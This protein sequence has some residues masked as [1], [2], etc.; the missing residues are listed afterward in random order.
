M[1]YHYPTGLCVTTSHD[2]LVKLEDCWGAVMKNDGRSYF[3]FK[4]DNSISTHFEKKSCVVV[5]SNP[6]DENLAKKVSKVEV[7]SV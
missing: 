1:L 2:K 4:E 7:S 6:K 5:P 3:I